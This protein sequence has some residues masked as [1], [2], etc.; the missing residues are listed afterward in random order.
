MGQH[1]SRRGCFF[2]VLPPQK[3]RFAG[4]NQWTAWGPNKR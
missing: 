4:A 2:F 3:R 1:V